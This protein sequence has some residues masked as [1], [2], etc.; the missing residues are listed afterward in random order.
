[1]CR[2]VR[3]GSFF[4]FFG[5]HVAVGK[6]KRYWVPVFGVKTTDLDVQAGGPIVFCKGDV[7][8]LGSVFG[9]FQ[10]AGKVLYEVGAGFC[11]GAGVESGHLLAPLLMNAL[12]YVL[13]IPYV[14]ILSSVTR[15]KINVDSGK[16]YQDG[17]RRAL[18]V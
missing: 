12:A 2:G 16:S 15:E 18:C 6:G 3:W 8:V 13:T 1:V 11:V 9:V 17:P 7:S 4:D 10:K 5:N 14:D